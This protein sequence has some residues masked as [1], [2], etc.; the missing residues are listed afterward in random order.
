[1]YCRHV[2]G[3]PRDDGIRAF[4][5]SRGYRLAEGSADDGP[6]QDT[7]QGLG[8]RKNALFTELLKRD[9]VEAYPH[10]AEL[11][12]RLR[13]AGIRTAVVSASKNCAAVLQAAGIAE[14][15]DVRVDG[16][17]REAMRLRGKPT[18]DTFLE[19]A[20]QLGCDP[21]RVMV[22]EDALA[23][24]E[25][26]QA[27][28]FGL[29]VGVNRNGDPQALKAH[30]ADVVISDLAQIRVRETGHAHGPTQAPTLPRIPAIPW[31]TP[32]PC[33]GLLDEIEAGPWI[34]SYESFD[35]AVEGRRE[36][37]FALG[38]GYVGT[39]GAAAESVA[40]GVHYPG[41][42]LAGGYNRQVSGISGRPVEHE[43]LVNW[44]NWLPITVRPANG[45]P[46]WLDTKGGTEIVQYR[47]ELDLRRG[48]YRRIVRFRDSRGRVT[49]LEERRFVHMREKHLAG[50]QVRVVAE[51]WSG[52]VT[53]CSAL[54]G[55]VTNA[56][57][58]RYRPFD[59]RHIEVLDAAASAADV[60]VLEAQTRQSR[61][62]MVQ[63]ARTR[64]YRHG[65][66]F[67]P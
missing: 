37:L 47:Q 67:E 6:D 43:D 59:G 58:L 30:G 4:L 62:R 27:G 13:A 63:A 65:Q 8:R 3:R 64:L 2:D 19:A 25:A 29:I 35:P 34:L 66:A 16:L 38:N 46:G 33:D 44:P 56:G 55:R 36:A 53:V 11:L 10:A 28:G 9:G 40:D 60:I 51:N 41:T 61:I 21:A 17:T 52:L 54:D 1:D 57:V 14:L 31:G 7:V 20:R 12:H 48:L 5:E 39:R 22:V 42:Y 23:G 50:I 26:G 18:P 32:V 49:R 45:A 24:V 15:F